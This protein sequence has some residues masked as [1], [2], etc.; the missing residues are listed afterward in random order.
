MNPFEDNVENDNA[1][2]ET[3]GTSPNPFDEP[4]TPF[5]VADIVGDEKVPVS[6]EDANGIT[7]DGGNRVGYATGLLLHGA[8]NSH[9]PYPTHMDSNEM[10]WAGPGRE[11][12]L[13]LRTSIVTS[14]TSEDRH[15]KK[16]VF[17]TIRC[18]T[19]PLAA[20]EWEAEWEW[21]VDRAYSDISA[22]HEELVK[23][24]PHRMSP[25]PNINVGVITD[26]YAHDQHERSCCSLA[27][28]QCCHSG[29]TVPL[30][31]EE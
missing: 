11:H 8:K 21:D 4:P 28:K 27:W 29:L 31:R 5:N 23:V 15:S 24:R 2:V 13:G 16:R 26:L 17:Y 19:L 10:H 12:P 14:R 6:E 7:R 18:C 1:F 9:T 25:K 30:Q 3:P 20:W 22:L